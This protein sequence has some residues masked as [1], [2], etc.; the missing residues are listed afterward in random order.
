MMGPAE[1]YKMQNIESLL[2][3]SP[4]IDWDSIQEIVRVVL[5]IVAA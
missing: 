5:P 4:L 2:L 3:H 1:Q